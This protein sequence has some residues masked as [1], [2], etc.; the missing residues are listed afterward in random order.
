MSPL[1]AARSNSGRILAVQAQRLAWHRKPM[2]VER[3]P[4]LSRQR[5]LQGTTQEAANWACQPSRASSCQSMPAADARMVCGAHTWPCATCCPVSCMPHLQR[6]QPRPGEGTGGCTGQ[7][8]TQA[9]AARQAQRHAVAHGILQERRRLVDDVGCDN[10]C[11]CF[12]EM[13]GRLGK[14]HT[15]LATPQTATG[16]LHM[17]ALKGG[18]NNIMVGFLCT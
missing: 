4:R 9:A 17:Q 3:P 6:L 10:K 14:R 18:T 2:R 7:R 11:E 13:A 12:T 8:N 15:P 16:R 1:A 5:S